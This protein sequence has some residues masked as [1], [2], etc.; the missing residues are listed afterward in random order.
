MKQHTRNVGFRIRPEIYK[1]MAKQAEKER[2]PVSEW[3]RKVII[4]ALK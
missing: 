3:I 1:K 2:L 4:E